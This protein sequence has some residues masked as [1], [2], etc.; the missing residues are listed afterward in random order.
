MVVEGSRASTFI[1]RSVMVEG[2]TVGMYLCKMRNWHCIGVIQ[3]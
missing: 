3:V 1:R 2:E